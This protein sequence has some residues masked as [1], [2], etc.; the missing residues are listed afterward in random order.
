MFVGKSVYNIVIV[1]TNINLL[2]ISLYQFT[3][4]FL[5]V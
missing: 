5:F 1:N 2:L 4:N 3:V